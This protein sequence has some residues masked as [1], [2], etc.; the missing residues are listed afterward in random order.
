MVPTAT[1]S[2]CQFWNDW[3]QKVDVETNP[4]VLTGS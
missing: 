3:N 2:L 1:N 4:A